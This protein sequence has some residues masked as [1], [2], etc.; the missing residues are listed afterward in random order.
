MGKGATLDNNNLLHRNLVKKLEP[1][2][3]F[4]ANRSMIQ[5]NKYFLS[6]IFGKAL[7]ITMEVLEMQFC[8]D[9]GKILTINV[10]KSKMKVD[11]LITGV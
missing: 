8:R 11:I 1:T 7:N 9:I 6:K 10:P 5:A 2:I 3:T 4:P